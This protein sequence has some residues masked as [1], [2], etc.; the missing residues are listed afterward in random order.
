M[1]N[2]QIR[3]G[4]VENTQSMDM[5]KLCLV[6]IDKGKEPLDRTCSDV[7]EKVCNQVKGKSKGKSMNIQRHSLPSSRETT[8]RGNRAGSSKSSLAKKI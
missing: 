7:V 3:S 8:W 2:T 1:E 4:G 6:V 5:E